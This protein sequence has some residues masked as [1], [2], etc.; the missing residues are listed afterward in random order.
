M[1]LTPLGSNI[2]PSDFISGKLNGRDIFIIVRGNNLQRPLVIYWADILAALPSGGSTVLLQTDGVDNTLQT[3]LN[4][5]EGNS[6]IG[7]TADA[8]GGV[9][10]SGLNILSS[11]IIEVNQ[12]TTVSATDPSNNHASLLEMGT[13][14]G[15][16]VFNIQYDL[17]TD[18][19]DGAITEILIGDSFD[20]PSGPGSVDIVVNYGV[21]TVFTGTVLSNR[22]LRFRYEADTDGWYLVNYGAGGGTIT[23]TPTEILYFDSLGNVTSDAN[24]TRTA[25]GTLIKNEVIAN[26]TSSTFGITDGGV[27]LWTAIGGPVGDYYNTI[28]PHIGLA[29]KS[30]VLKGANFAETI[31]NSVLI[32][33]FDISFNGSA[34]GGYQYIFPTSSPTTGQVLAS[35]SS[36]QL[37]W[38]TP[39]GGGTVTSVNAGTNISVTGTAT[40]PII[41][42]LSDR[43]RTSSV[44]SNSV[45]NGAKTFIVDLNLSYIPLQEILIVYDPANHMHGEVTS[46]NPATGSLVVDIKNHTGS[47]TYTSWTINLDGTPVDA[48]SGLGVANEIAYFTGAQTLGSLAVAT[49]PSLTEL[50]YVKGVTSAIQTQMNAKAP[51]ASPAFTGSPTAPTQSPSDNSTKIA[52]TAYVDNAVGAPQVGSDLYLFYNY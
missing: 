40:D 51:L 9:S 33:K 41:N 48:I 26:Q 12:N 50:S 10:I 46:Y 43:Y 44:T 52:T 11:E 21:T 6:Y 39:S 36:G 32:N 13:W 42:S 47:G 25:A 23:G 7:L 19:E 34:G 45:S 30:I 20:T 4:L 14:D 3:K 29:S 37:G 24:A 38:V 2:I 28:S 5:I 18:P 22:T 1:P 15:L 31:Y 49:Y 35:V 27:G 17:K 8:L 16:S